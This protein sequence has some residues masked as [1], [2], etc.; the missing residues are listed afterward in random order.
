M[1]AAVHESATDP[2]RLDR[3]NTYFA[4]VR[5]HERISGAVLKGGKLPSEKRGTGIDLRRQR[6]PRRK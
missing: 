3:D 1:F 6:R 5:Y 4:P 2:Q